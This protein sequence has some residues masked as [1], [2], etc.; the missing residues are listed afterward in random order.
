VT[1]LDVGVVS[2]TTTKRRRFLWCAWWA[3]PPARDPFR[4]PDA[5]SGGARSL[6]EA[7]R[8]AEEAAGRTLLLVD[9]GWA[10]A[11]VRLRAGLPPWPAPR[12]PNAEDAARVAVE[13]PR[14]GALAVLGLARGATLEEIKRAY[15]RRALETHPDRGGDEAAFVRVQRA[16]EAAMRRAGKRR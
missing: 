14:A 6:E 12:P 1:A 8:A 10:R 13:L 2:I 16:Y 5:W 11:F 4:P 7:K 3:A 9:S 15:R